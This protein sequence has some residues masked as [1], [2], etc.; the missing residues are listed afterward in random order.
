MVVGSASARSKGVPILL[1]RG[2]TYSSSSRSLETKK[3]KRGVLDT[4]GVLRKQT[5][6]LLVFVELAGEAMQFCPSCIYA[7]AQK[8]GHACP[9][10]RIVQQLRVILATSEFFKGESHVP[11]FSCSICRGL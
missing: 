11:R 4:R 9:C 3:S 7:Q 1:C 6:L 5:V 10:H 2:E 8:K